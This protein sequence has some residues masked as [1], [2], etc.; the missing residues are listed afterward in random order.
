MTQTGG[1]LI[2]VVGPSGAGK[3]TL[4]D[5]ARDRFAGD[6]RFVFPQRLITRTDQ[7]GEAHEHLAATGFE[8]AEGFLL[9]WSAHG[10]RYGIPAAARDE[11]R[12][13][14]CVVVNVSRGVI[15]EAKRAWPR[16]ALVH[17]TAPK[18]VLRERLS[19]RGREDDAEIEARL[20]RKQTVFVPDDVALVTIENSG[21]LETAVARFTDLL[22]RLAA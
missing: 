14:R 4:L 2:C 16:L 7:T 10:E 5:A 17:I 11:L 21:A 20:S 18:P 1:I 15:A 8:T 13:G 9:S 12:A 19:R 6:S 3:D 22:E